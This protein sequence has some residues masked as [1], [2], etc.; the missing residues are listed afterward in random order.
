MLVEQGVSVMKGFK[1]NTNHDSFLYIM[2]DP[3][4]PSSF[5]VNGEGADPRCRA[6]LP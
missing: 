6:P 3:L 1:S 2:P 4:C 5:M